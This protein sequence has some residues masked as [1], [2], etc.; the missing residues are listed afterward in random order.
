[1]RLRKDIIAVLRDPSDVNPADLPYLLVADVLA[2]SP[3]AVRVLVNRGMGCAG[4]PFARFE[5]V[6]EVARI[7]HVDVGD[8]AAAL[9]EA[10]SIGQTGETR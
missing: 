3:A 9:M 2:W 5:T 8:L 6:A 7:Y 10:G 4:C 1:M